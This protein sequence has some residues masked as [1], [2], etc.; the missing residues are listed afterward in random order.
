MDVR[1][2]EDECVAA[3]RARLQ[4][5]GFGE[6]PGLDRDELVRR[7]RIA[8]G[9]I[10][11]IIATIALANLGSGQPVPTVLARLVYVAIELPL[12]FYFVA[13]AYDYA[14][15]RRLAPLPTL[16]VS[17][18]ASV[19][20]G[21]VTS[22]LYWLVA[23]W[24]PFVG[25]TLPPELR[26]RALAAVACGAAVGIVHLGIFALAFVYP[27]AAHDARVRALEAERLRTA[28]ELARLRGHLEPHFLL[29][30]LN[31]IAGLVTEDPREARRLLAALGDLLRDALRD[32]G[33]LQTLE[34]E[35]AW[36]RRYAE[37]LESRH[38]G[39]LAFRWQIEPEVRQVQVPRLLLQPLVENA[40]KHGALRRRGGGVVTVRAQRGED[41]A[42]VVCVVED[43]GPGFAEG[44]IRTG[45]V[46]LSVVRRRLELNL[47]GG[48]L[49][50]ESSTEGT[51]A[52]I[53]LRVPSGAE[54]PAFSGARPLPSRAQATA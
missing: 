43:D 5:Y 29:N 40:V 51:R 39:A 32:G 17:G 38:K 49:R 47:D 20:I 22:V 44:P 15:R 16:L 27:F 48:I 13:R 52:I 4:S 24:S 14:L 45:A 18:G 9:V 54:V 46:G 2:E 7:R 25:E 50:L 6:I 36:L 34:E 33:E 12:L 31:A 1:S 37:I 21:V 30:T 8:T 3:V 10:T 26:E 42:S 11:T 41:Q 23:R 53:E 19:T 35:E 28:A